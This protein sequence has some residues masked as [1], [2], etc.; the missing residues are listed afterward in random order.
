MTASN[1]VAFP[2]ERTRQTLDSILHR[3]EQALEVGRLIRAEV[4]REMDWTTIQLNDLSAPSSCTLADLHLTAQ[5]ARELPDF[6]T[7]PF[8]GLKP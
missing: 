7:W 4:A 2:L 3:C 5:K 1:I 6:N 8:N